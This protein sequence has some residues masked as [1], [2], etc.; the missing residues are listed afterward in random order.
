MASVLN[1]LSVLPVNL[2]TESNE[3]LVLAFLW[4]FLYMI[5]SIKYPVVFNSSWNWKWWGRMWKWRQNNCREK[6]ENFLKTFFV[7][8]NWWEVDYG[9]CKTGTRRS[10]AYCIRS[11][12][13]KAYYY[14]LSWNTPM[15]L[16]NHCLIYL[17][18]SCWTPM[19]VISTSRDWYW[20][21]ANLI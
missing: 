16:V 7:R 2:I 5:K 14:S 3:G 11:H 6:Q 13:Y 18:F 20:V 17:M 21:T 8:R 10:F 15:S 12:T 9:A 1:N 4:L 19:A